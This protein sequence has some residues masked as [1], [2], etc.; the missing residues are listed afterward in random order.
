MPPASSP[1]TTRMRRT[2][3]VGSA[4]P[5]PASRRR[6]GCRARPIWPRRRSRRRCAPRAPDRDPGPS[7]TSV[8]RSR[9]PRQR[10]SAAAAGNPLRRSF[11]HN[12]AVSR[13]I[14]L[15]AAG[16]VVVALLAVGPLGL[17]GARPA[18]SAAP[19][20][21][22][23]T[24]RAAIDLDRIAGRGR[25]TQP[26]TGRDGVERPI[27][28]RPDR[29][30]A[31]RPGHQLPGDTDLDGPDRGQVGRW[32]G[33]ALGTRRSSSSPARPMRSWRPSASPGRPTARGSSWPPA[34]RRSRRTSRRT[35]SASRSCA[36]TRSGPRSA[37]STGATRRCSGSTGSRI[38]PPGP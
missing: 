29:G 32:P 23:G 8:G 5:G 22:S 7:P 34:R 9:P 6:R 27:P 1:S 38:W 33:P 21:P 4:M 20:P 24:R 3:P 19:T 35:A 25:W 36:P 15:A 26:V 16:F 37:R 12:P 17:L 18:P 11:C 31:D 30:R 28:D 2:S 14:R 10:L 13:W